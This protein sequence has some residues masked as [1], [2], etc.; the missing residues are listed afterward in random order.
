[1]RDHLKW[2]APLLLLVS[3]CHADGIGGDVG[4]SSDEVFR[5][6]SQS[7]H[8][9]SPQLDLH[10]SFSGWYA[11]LTAVG[12][13]RGQ[14]ESVRAGLIAYL[15]YQYRLNDDW[16]MS[17]AARHYDYPGYPY[18]HYYDYEEGALSV[19]WRELIVATVMASPN[20]YFADFQGRAARGPAYTYE[21]GGRLPLAYGF[22]ANAGVGYYNLDRQIGT[23]YAYWSTGISKQWRSVNFDLRYVGTD[24]TATRRFEQFAENR[25]VFSAL[26][27]F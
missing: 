6:L 4:I 8:Q 27:L 25:L 12:V 9:W 15:G 13:R 7:D 16:A 1:M 18:R 22:C 24:E 11:G 17:L 26:Y 2:F 3:V 23:G 10:Y 21:I 19:S 5:G 14:Y 20:V